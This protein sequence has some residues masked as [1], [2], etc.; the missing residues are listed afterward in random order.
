MTPADL[1]FE[2]PQPEDLVYLNHAGISPWPRRAALAVQRFADEN[3]LSGPLHY[4]RWIETETTLREQLRCLINARST[5]EIALLKNTSE[6]LSF[7]AGGLSWSRDDNIVACDQEFPSNRIPWQ[8]LSE[9]DVTLREV[10]LPPDGDLETALMAACDG[11]T[12]LLTISS[13]QFASG[14]RVDLDVLGAFCRAR[15]ILFCIDAIQGLGALPLDV[16]TCHADFV[17]ADAHKWLLGPEGI[18]LFYVAERVWDR[19]RPSEYG[20]HMTTRPGDYDS[21]SWRVADSARRFECGSPNLLGAHAFSA[22]LSLILEIGIAAISRTVI[23]NTIYLFDQLENNFG[24]MVLSRGAAQRLS[25]IVSFR[26]RDGD[27]ATLH[28]RLREHGVVCAVRGGAIRWS[29]HFYTPRDKL[30]RALALLRSP[31]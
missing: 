12:R 2:F 25:G 19:I 4:D 5:D 22:S 8:A 15:G 10:A 16:A 1:V 31:R 24:A 21:K 11:H 13:V 3:I 27:V 28:R 20:W 6:G 7:V 26:P 18:A 23:N 9:R 14:F 29:P 30:T 17:V